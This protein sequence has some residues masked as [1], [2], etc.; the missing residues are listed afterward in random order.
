MK[1]TTIRFCKIEFRASL[2]FA[3]VQVFSAVLVIIGALFFNSSQSRL[4][5][6]FYIPGLPVD[7]SFSFNWA[8]NFGF[9][10]FVLIVNST[11]FSAYLPMTMI[12][13]N[14]SCWII[15]IAQESINNLTKVLDLP[16]QGLIPIEKTNLVQ[17]ELEKVVDSTCDIIEWQKKAQKLLQLS[18]LMEFSLLSIVLCMSLTTLHNDLRD[19]LSIG[20]ILNVCIA[21]L[22]ISCWIGSRIK[23][24]FDLLSKSLFGMDW[25]RLRGHQ[26]KN[27]ELLLLM[28]QNLKGFNGVFKSVDLSTFQKVK[29]SSG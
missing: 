17:E 18:F 19:S 27:V 16:G 22:F 14:H 8:I 11:F 29:T 1:T 9:Q 26:R 15:D 5:L 3:A 10:V 23:T 7:G 4:P 25:D 28:C 24:R 2:I 20:P 12:F 21:Q 6:A 13:M